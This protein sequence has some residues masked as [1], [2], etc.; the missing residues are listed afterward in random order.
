M[1]QHHWS[2]DP[3]LRTTSEPYPSHK[4]ACFAA[5]S[6]LG[7]TPSE[8]NQL[9]LFGDLYDD[10]GTLRVAIYKRDPVLPLV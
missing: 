10:F 5:A 2:T 1:E 7:L 4:D 6:E 3:E 8:T 9:L